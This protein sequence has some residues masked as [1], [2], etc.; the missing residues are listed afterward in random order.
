[1]LVRTCEAAGSPAH[2]GCRIVVAG[3]GE[4]YVMNVND[5]KHAKSHG[6][7]AAAR[8]ECPEPGARGKAWNPPAI[9]RI[10]A[11]DSTASGGPYTATNETLYTTP[12]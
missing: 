10:D 4:V 1:M 11:V 6:A 9:R 2:D 3:Y 8:G 5:D 7:S 12:S